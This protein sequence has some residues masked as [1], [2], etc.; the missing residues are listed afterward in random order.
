MTKSKIEGIIPDHWRNIHVATEEKLIFL[1][2][3]NIDYLK[4]HWRREERELSNQ[5]KDTQTRIDFLDGKDVYDIQKIAMQYAYPEDIQRAIQQDE[6]DWIVRDSELSGE[7]T[8]NYCGYCRYAGDRFCDRKGQVITTCTLLPKS[9][10]HGAYRPDEFLPTSSC[11]LVNHGK[12]VIDMSLACLRNDL[13]RLIRRKTE[14]GEYIRLLVDVEKS[15]E[16]KP[17]FSAYRPSDWFKIG[18]RVII[19]TGKSK[20]VLPEKRNKF[21]A[22]RVC[23][24]HNN[25]VSV[26]TYE[27]TQTDGC[28]YVTVQA[29]RPEI[30]HAWEHE[31]LK[32]HH[33]FLRLWLRASAESFRFDAFSIYRAFGCC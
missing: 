32:N 9:Y 13:D 31:Y 23:R 30:M 21:V 12:E 16:E 8:F 7:T 10:G 19:M 20:N 15:A 28:A 3:R 17:Y 18:D 25:I 27:P 11:E 2:T 22:G 33:D 24:C 14:V 29:F 26:R 6:Y 1:G 4:Q 5:I